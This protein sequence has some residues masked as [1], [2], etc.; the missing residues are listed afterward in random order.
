MTIEKFK[1][2]WKNVGLEIPIYT[3]NIESYRFN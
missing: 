2:I 3:E 1:Q